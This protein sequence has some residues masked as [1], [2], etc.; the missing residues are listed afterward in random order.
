[1]LE[2]AA[3]LIKQGGIVVFPTETV[4]GIGT[5]GLNAEAVKRLYEVKRRPLNTS[6]KHGNG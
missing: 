4:Y 5:N 1:M 2:K 3:E 6:I